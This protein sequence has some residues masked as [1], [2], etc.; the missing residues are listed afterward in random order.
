MLASLS[1]RCGTKSQLAFEGEECSGVVGSGLTVGLLK[2]GATFAISTR[3][4]L[5]A[6]IGASRNGRKVL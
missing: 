1:L 3:V 6:S 4:S 5:L 2:L